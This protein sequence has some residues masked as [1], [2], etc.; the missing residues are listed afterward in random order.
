L[1]DLR[2]KI[3]AYT[4]TVRAMARLVFRGRRLQVT[5]PQA[6]FS[7]IE[8]IAKEET[9]SLSSAVMELV[10]EGIKSRSLSKT[11]PGNS[12]KD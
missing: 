4:K 2:F 11:N 6:L 12:S 8:E 3:N 5:F 9:K 1:K 10:A 7:Q